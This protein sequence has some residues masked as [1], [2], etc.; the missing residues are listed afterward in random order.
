MKQIKTIYHYHFEMDNCGALT[1]KDQSKL[2]STYQDES[3]I[4][5]GSDKSSLFTYKISKEDL[6]YDIGGLITDVANLK[7]RVKPNWKCDVSG[8]S[9]CEFLESDIQKYVEDYNKNTLKTRL[10]YANFMTCRNMR[11]CKRTLK[12][13][14]KQLQE[15]EAEIASLEQKYPSVR[16]CR[17]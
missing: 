1:Y 2:K 8:Y 5:L 3:H 12:N 10:H 4:W 14:K 6:V 9:P 15:I 11:E 17:Y 13:K 16:N 7:P